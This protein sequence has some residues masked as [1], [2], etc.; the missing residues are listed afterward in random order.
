MTILNITSRRCPE[1]HPRLVAVGI[2]FPFAHGHLLAGAKWFSLQML[3]EL[4]CFLS[5]FL[6]SD[7]AYYSAEKERRP[8]FRKALGFGGKDYLLKMG[9]R[10]GQH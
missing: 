7:G 6:P 5:D 2:S 3:G 1:I 8:W 9:N 10:L 4:S